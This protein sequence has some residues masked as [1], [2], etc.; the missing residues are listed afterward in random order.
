MTRPLQQL[1]E[2][3]QDK[4]H[5]C[6]MPNWTSPML[7]TL[8]EKRFSDSDWIYERKLDG[9]RCLAFVNGKHISLKSRNQQT[10]NT[11][12]PEIVDALSKQNHNFIVDGEIVA[13]SK[14]KTSFERLQKRMRIS[15]KQDA[16]NSNVKVYF[17]IFDIL[18]YDDNDVTGLPLRTRK[19]LL[20]QA[21]NFSDGLR[22]TRHRNENGEAYHEEACKKGWE[23]IIAKDATATYSHSRST[24]WLKFKCVNQQELVIGGYT[25]PQGERSHFGAILVGY[26]Q[27]GSFHYAGK[28]GT[29]FDE[30]TLKEL[31][32][33]FKQQSRKS[34]PF[35]EE[36]QIRERSAHWLNPKLVAE[37]GFTEWTR[38]GKLRHPR[39]LGL[40]HD[41]SP[42][43]VVK[44]TAH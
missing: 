40:R 3:L 23:G 31:G 21:V 43:Q 18:Y 4:L 35:E 8:T 25:E 14:G 33:K 39:Y 17:Y 28:V 1:P 19:K 32:K 38:D 9:E 13:F 27:N 10:L 44:E 26:Y 2:T 41:K 24:K 20:R 5:Q 11:T 15:D 22:Y 37:I 6:K 36:D 30:Q 7:A 34:C 12:Y 16:R 29:G 42:K